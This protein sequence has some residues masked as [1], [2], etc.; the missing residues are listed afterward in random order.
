MTFTLGRAPEK[1]NVVLVDDADFITALHRVD[2][3]PWPTTLV[4]TIEISTDPATMWEGTVDGAYI[5]WEVDAADVS[6]VRA[7]RPKKAKLWYVDGGTRL[8]WASGTVTLA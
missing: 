5:R 7:L 2:D 1:F 4:A 8:L 3:S 6:T